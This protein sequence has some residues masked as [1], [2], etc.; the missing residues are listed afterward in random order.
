MSE[1]MDAVPPVDE[2]QVRNADECLQEALEH[3]ASMFENVVV[4]VEGA[5]D[6][7]RGYFRF[8]C[9]GSPLMH[10]GMARYAEKCAS[11][12]MDAS[13]EDEDGEYLG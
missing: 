2:E 13:L 3:L 11:E 9:R 7:D 8:E 12:Q 1:P 6:A 5:L 4:I 10:I